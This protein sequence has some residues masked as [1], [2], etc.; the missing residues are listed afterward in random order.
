MRRFFIRPATHCQE[1]DGKTSLPSFLSPY[2][3]SET[4]DILSFGQPASFGIVSGFC[5]GFFLKKVGKAAIVTSGVVFILLQSAAQAGYLSI[6]WQAIE[7]DFNGAIGKLKG[8]GTVSLEGATESAGK[9]LTE[10]TGIASGAFMAGFLI[11][12]KRG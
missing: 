8:N 7:K 4:R 10:K 12:V 1:T 9:Y 6:N 3:S 5:S 11:G 2:L